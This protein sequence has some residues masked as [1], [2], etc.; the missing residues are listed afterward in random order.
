MSLPSAIIMV[1]GKEK[2][3]ENE[4]AVVK[5]PIAVWLQQVAGVTP[6]Q[7]VEAMKGSW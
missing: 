7:Y 2:M 6:E 5:D 4:K 1:V 3:S